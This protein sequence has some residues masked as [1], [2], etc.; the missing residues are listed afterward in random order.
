MW[1]HSHIYYA[2]YHCYSNSIVILPA[3]A[4]ASLPIQQLSLYIAAVALDIVCCAARASD[5]Y[6][7]EH[8]EITP[9]EFS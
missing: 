2:F 7:L 9:I 1:Q 4:A 6:F 3:A 8:E 5:H